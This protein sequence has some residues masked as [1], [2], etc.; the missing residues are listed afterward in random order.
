MV[1]LDTLWREDDR[2]SLLEDC[3]RFLAFHAEWCVVLA[4][5]LLHRIDCSEGYP[6]EVPQLN[7]HANR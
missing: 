2:T 3:F 4:R 1:S 5:F 7:R 6:T